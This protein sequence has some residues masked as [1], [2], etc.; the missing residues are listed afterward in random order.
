MTSAAPSSRSQP[1]LRPEPS[2]SRGRRSSARTARRS[3]RRRP[4]RRGSGSAGLVRLRE[5]D[6][7]APGGQRREGNAGGFDVR[8]GL[9]FA[10][11]LSAAPRRTRRRFRRSGEPPPCRRPRRPAEADGLV[12]GRD[13]DAAEVVAE[14]GRELEHRAETPRPLRVLASIGFTPAAT[15]CTRNSELAVFGCSIS[16]MVK[17]SGAP[18]PSMMMARIVLIPWPPRRVI[19]V[20]W[21]N[22]SALLRACQ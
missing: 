13:D 10:A 20:N 14:H 9:R 2:R 4:R 6:H 19:P 18:V 7:H 16:A 11:R 12:G 15:T 21:L 5:L 3:G 8:E 1:T 17:T 22:E